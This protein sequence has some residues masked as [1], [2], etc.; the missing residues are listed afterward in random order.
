MR[1]GTKE[2]GLAFNNS[3]DG[4]SLVVAGRK[5][6]NT[7]TDLQVV[8]SGVSFCFKKKKS[9]VKGTLSPGLQNEKH[10]FTW[11]GNPNFF[12]LR[13]YFRR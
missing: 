3:V 13:I 8:E 4:S 2:E 11:I 10:W 5:A 12:T 1:S 9:L 6:E 7:G